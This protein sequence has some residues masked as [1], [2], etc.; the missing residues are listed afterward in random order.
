MSQKLDVIIGKTHVRTDCA[1]S[2]RYAPLNSESIEKS[3]PNTEPHSA[4]LRRDSSVRKDRRHLPHWRLSGSFNYVTW[5]LADSLPQEKLKAWSE[6]KRI[7]LQRNPKPWD[8][9]TVSEYGD[10][11]PKKLEAWLDLGYGS[12]F[13]RKPECGQIVANAFRFFDGERY[14]LSSFVIMPNHVHAL[15]QLCIGWEIEEVSHSLKSYTANEIN[16]ALGRK[17]AVWQQEGFDHLLRGVAHL[18]RCLSYIRN[19]PSAAHLKADE[20]ISYEVPGFAD[21][22]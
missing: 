2:Q 20:Y 3:E 18:D 22:L 13:L 16:K 10:R 7:W 14:D 17:G 4:F 19:N 21:L 12:C 15:F 9:A 5:R 11:F 8:A 6:E 1:Y